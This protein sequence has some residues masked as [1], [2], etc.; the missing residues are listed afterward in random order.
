VTRPLSRKQERQELVAG[1]RAEG[2]TWVQIADVLRERYDYNARAAMRVA[3]GWSQQR[4]ADEWNRRW[5]DELKTAKSFS[6]WETWPTSGHAPSL[7]VLDQLAQLYECGA[8]DL[9]VDVSDYRYR[10]ESSTE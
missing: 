8:A 6:H 2:K 5:R 4:A 9:L 3:H 10:D 7:R 1:L